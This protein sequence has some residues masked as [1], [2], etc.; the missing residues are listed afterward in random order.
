MNLFNEF[1]AKGIFMKI[2]A[3]SDVDTNERRSSFIKYANS[4]M[5]STKGVNP[6]EKANTEN[7]KPAKLGIENIQEF[8]VFP[9]QVVDGKT[10]ITA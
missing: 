2:S 9:K 3:I 1:V 7:K 6:I 5:S 8:T 10:V 4:F